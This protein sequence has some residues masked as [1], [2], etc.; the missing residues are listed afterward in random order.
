MNRILFIDTILLFFLSWTSGNQQTIAGWAEQDQKSIKE[1]C[2]EFFRRL[3]E[4]DDE[5]V[6]DD[7]QH[8]V[9]LLQVLDLLRE[10][11]PSDPS[12]T[13]L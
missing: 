4:D 8:T 7:D 2:E 12:V 13:V 1:V 10:H 5:D 3:V 6:V 11:C 9:R